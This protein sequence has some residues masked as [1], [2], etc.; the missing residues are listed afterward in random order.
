MGSLKVAL[1]QINSH[2]GY[3]DF[4]TQKIIDSIEEAKAKQA[5][6]IVF[7]ELSISGYTARDLWL[8]QSFTDQCNR[9]IALIKTHCLGILAIVG[10]TVEENGSCYDVAHVIY[11][12]EILITHKKTILPASSLFEE[13]RYFKT[14]NQTTVF[15]YNDH[16]IGVRICEELWDDKEKYP[17]C[18]LI[19]CLS[20][21]PWT[22][23][24][25][26]EREHSLQL[27]S[28]DTKTPIIFVNA[29]SYENNLILEGGSSIFNA[30]GEKALQLPNF[31]EKLAFFDFA[32]IDQDVE[33]DLSFG[34]GPESL[35]KALCFSLKDYI[36]KNKKAGI[37]L[38]ITEDIN[39]FLIFA[40]AV[41]AL[42]A[43]KVSAFFLY[44]EY[45]PSYLS[46]AV[47]KA[48]TALACPIHAIGTGSTVNSFKS[49][50]EPL[51]IEGFGRLELD[52]LPSNINGFLLSC[53]SKQTDNALI[54]TINKTELAL[55]SFD[56]FTAVK[57]DFALI[58]DLYQYEVLELLE[59]RNS[60]TPFIDPSVISAIYNHFQRQL[61]LISPTVSYADI[62]DIL[63]RYIDGNQS[64]S[65]IINA[66]FDADHVHEITYIVDNSQHKRTKFAICPKLSHRS[67]IDDWR[68][69]TLH[70][71]SPPL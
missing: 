67:L 42:G 30:A 41:D 13:R 6:I 2:A 29:L 16:K 20:A 62:D 1:A 56:Q 21:V 53:L 64:P 35:Y 17:E 5:D 46:E 23:Y 47:H 4:N 69:P 11:N 48:A 28:T 32:M 43:D 68:M 49:M 31:E 59:Y 44:E 71:W 60:M 8:R 57:S 33:P 70:Q 45:T 58:S 51:F 26:Y 38:P 19:I 40:I 55:A 12:G 22:K 7:P 24:S 36:A 52:N 15:K 37:V 61:S 65:R 25:Q 3:V 63:E 14:G 27:V 18:D 10:S 50:V 66:G 39:S 54:S 9:A 34:V